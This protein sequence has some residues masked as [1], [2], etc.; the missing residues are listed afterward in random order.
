MITLDWSERL[1]VHQCTPLLL[2]FGLI[3]M[4]LGNL[5]L[6]RLWLEGLSG[7]N[8]E[9]GYG[10]LLANIRRLTIFVL[11]E[12][13]QESKLKLLD[14]TE[15]R[16]LSSAAIR[17]MRLWRTVLREGGSKSATEKLN[18]ISGLL[19]KRNGSDRDTTVANQA[20]P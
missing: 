9:D 12:L 13:E 16:M 8:R 14:P 15:K 3:P 1:T 5:S 20:P 19:T 6:G 17:L 7:E 4:I 10:E 2:M 11:D 18:K